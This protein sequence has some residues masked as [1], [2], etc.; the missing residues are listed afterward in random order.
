MREMYYKQE[1]YIYMDCKIRMSKKGLSDLLYAAIITKSGLPCFFGVGIYQYSRSQNG[2]NMV[3]VKVHI[4]PD[5]VQEFENTA[6]VKLFKP[7][8]P[9][10]NHPTT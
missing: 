2:F 4:H 8:S 7:I 6:G 10:V 9:T 1:E 5:A 3:D